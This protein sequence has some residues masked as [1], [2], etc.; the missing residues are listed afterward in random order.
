MQILRQDEL[1]NAISKR[2]ASGKVVLCGVGNDI[3]GD[4]G[5]GLYLIKQLGASALLPTASTLSCGEM[6]ENHI[7]EIVGLDPSHVVIMDAVDVGAPP[8]S[9]VLVESN[10]IHRRAIS[11]HRLPMSLLSRLIAVASNHEVDVFILG[12]QAVDYAF[13]KGLSLEVREAADR[14]VSVLKRVL[15]KGDSGEWQS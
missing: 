11:T 15:S 6:P 13:G 8:G 14:L 7:P 4:D 1:T 2:L 9:T 3:R 5:V 10:E 12:I